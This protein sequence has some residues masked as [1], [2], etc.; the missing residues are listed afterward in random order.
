MDCCGSKGTGKE[1]GDKEARPQGDR[2]AFRRWGLWLVLALL[3]V[4]MI[5]GPLLN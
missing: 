1:K 4:G 3:V 2:G 5:V